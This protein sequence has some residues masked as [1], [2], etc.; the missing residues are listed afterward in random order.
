MDEVGRYMPDPG[1]ILEEE[2]MFPIKFAFPLAKF[3]FACMFA[4][5]III[6][7]LLFL[8]LSSCIKA[9][10]IFTVSSGEVD[11]EPTHDIVVPFQYWEGCG[12]CNELELCT[13]GCMAGFTGTGAAAELVIVK[14]SNGEN[15]D[16]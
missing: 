3:R 5:G 2:V 6:F 1:W 9:S 11:E 10:L 14:R 16:G 15:T 13:M 8:K 12:A 7:L 4:K